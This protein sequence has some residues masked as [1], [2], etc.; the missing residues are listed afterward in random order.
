MTRPQ[1]S[2]Y[3]IGRSMIE[4]RSING[5]L[6]GDVNKEADLNQYIESVL[7]WSIH[8]TREMVTTVLFVILSCIIYVYALLNVEVDECRDFDGV[9]FKTCLISC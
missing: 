7:Y 2:P 3:F 4:A 6:R 9:I 5:G 1:S 8:P